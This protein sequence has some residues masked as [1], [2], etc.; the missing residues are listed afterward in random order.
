[1][2]YGHWTNTTCW[3]GVQVYIC[4]TTLSR[5]FNTCGRS[6]LYSCDAAWIQE[7]LTNNVKLWSSVEVL[8]PT[9]VCRDEN[10]L[11]LRWSGLLHLPGSVRLTEGLRK[12]KN[13]INYWRRQPVRISLVHILGK[14]ENSLTRGA[15]IMDSVHIKDSTFPY[16]PQINKSPSIPCT[17]S[18]T[19]WLNYLWSISTIP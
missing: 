1:M 2:K 18:Q 11:R 14:N 9:C 7:S 16:I 15:W 4:F 10:Q 17:V 13:S 6:F 8:K 3:N 5:F 12:T 19:K